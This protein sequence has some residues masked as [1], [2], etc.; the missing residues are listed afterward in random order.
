MR[1]TPSGQRLL[2][3]IV[4]ALALA[5]G[6]SAR[7]AEAARF[8]V[9]RVNVFMGTSNSRWMIFPGAALPWGLVKLSPDNQGNVWNGGYEYTVN[10]ISGFSHLHAMSLSGLSL[11]PVTG[12]LQLDPSSSR[13]HPGSADGPF[14]TMWTAGYRSRFLK[15]TEKASPGYYSVELYDYNVKVELSATLR[16]GFLRLTYPQSDQSHLFIDFDFPAEEQNEILLVEFRR[17]APGEFAGHVRQ[18]NGYAGIHD[19]YFVT[20]LNLDPDRVLIWENG[21]YTGKE[22]NY[23]TAWRRPCKF[24]ELGASFTGGARTG[25]ILNFK[26]K[27]GQQVLVRSGL[28]FVGEANAR[29]NLETES[30]PFGWDFDRVVAAARAT[31][32]D[33]LGRIEVSAENPALVETFYSCLYRVFS[34]KSVLNDVNGE[35]LDANR[36]LAKVKAPADAVYSGDGL[37][38]VQW[39]MAPLWTLV[40]PEKAVSMVNS[41]LT[42][43]D[44]GGWIPE[45]PTALKY[46]PI[47]GAQHHNAVII[48]A[49]QKGLTGFDAED[50]YAKMRHDLTTQG[51]AFPDGGFAGNRFMQVYT[52][53]GF[54]PDESGPSS[55]TMEYAYDDWCLGQMARKLGRTADFEY[56]NRRSGNW[57]NAWNPRLG[58][59]WRRHADGSWVEPFD[60]M[61]F[62]TEGGWNGRGFME[63]NALVYSFWV[64]QDVPGLVALM[65]AENFNRTLGDSLDWG[66][67]DASN[68]PTLQTPYLFNYSGMP[69]L[70]Q[71]YSRLTLDR[72][73]DNSP[74]RGWPGEEDEGQLSAYMIL[75]AC[76]LFEMDGGC[77]VDP[78][79][80]ISS[81]AFRQIA[82]HLD[83]RYYPGREFV[84]ETDQQAPGAVYIQSAELNGKP[85]ERLKL[86]HADLVKGG[87]LSLHLGP[88]PNKNWGQP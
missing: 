30:R 68:E 28:S 18:K 1:S 37:W 66:D 50:A 15:Q 52:D 51:V 62:G 67:L 60:R 58:S 10:S 7:A 80:D 11:M 75:L 82:I 24:T 41:L 42:L 6:G 4:L 26:T 8:A 13:L 65:G 72:Y 48:S 77:A 59:V 9:D 25:A 70:T 39:D 64:P 73:F 3:P 35:F 85:F 81:P 40:A 14:G 69:W 87:T 55:L 46:A 20:Q 36:R 47:M 53:K 63:G 45:A 34:G 17:T 78:Y 49:Y 32:S 56:F 33:L 16:C 38:G 71:K 27:A 12:A 21:E 22:T 19:L 61:R 57:R 76:G 5:L 84:I 54:V 44:R 31:W 74:Y 88:S 2:S 86:R 23:G 29:L 79:Y 83:P 43:A